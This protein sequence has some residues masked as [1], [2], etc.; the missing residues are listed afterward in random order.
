[1]IPQLRE[2]LRQIDNSVPVENL[3]PLADQAGDTS[4]LDRVISM[5][6]S[7]FA[8]VAMLLAGIGLYGV[9][10]YNLAQ[11]TREIGLHM[12]LGATVGSVRR[13][14]FR[15]VGPIAF[16]GAAAGAIAAL[17]IGRIAES[18]LFQVAGYNV[19]VMVAACA[20]VTAI[21]LAAGT[22]PAWRASR[23]DPMQALRCE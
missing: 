20:A 16:I 17:A 2:V 9:L 12:A 14:V 18:M 15:Q 1:V 22:V 21:A 7:G 8:A 10:S 4:T 13:M 5:L 11:R 6:A 23:I 3:R 19:T